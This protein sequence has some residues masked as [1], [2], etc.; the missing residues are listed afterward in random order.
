[1][2]LTDFL[3]RL[4]K[5]WAEDSNVKIDDGWGL[6]AAV[7]KEK[8][9]YTPE[10]N[11]SWIETLESWRFHR[12]CLWHEC[13]HLIYSHPSEQV[14]DDIEK[15]FTVKELSKLSATLIQLVYNIIEDYRIEK[16]GLLEYPGYYSEKRF[17]AQLLHENLIKSLE[18]SN[19]EVFRFLACFCLSL[20]DNISVSKHLNERDQKLLLELLNLCWDVESYHDGIKATQEVLRRLLKRFP[21]LRDK[22]AALTSKKLRILSRLS[23]NGRRYA[24]WE[25]LPE[26]SRR[27]S[28]VRAPQPIIREYESLIKA[29][30]KASFEESQAESSEDLMAALRGGAGRLTP[31]RPSDSTQPFDVPSFMVNRLIALLRQWRGGW[32]EVLSEVG[33]DVEV[34]LY[35]LDRLR[36]N[37]ERRFWLDEEKLLPGGP[38]ALLLDLSGSIASAGLVEDYLRSAILIGKALS[39]LNVPFSI[40]AF[41]DPDFLVVKQVREPWSRAVEAR[42]SALREGAG[43]PLCDALKL[44]LKMQPI[45]G[46]RYL[47]VLTDGLPNDERASM[48]MIREFEARGIKVLI[49][50]FPPERDVEVH[51]AFFRLVNRKPS[52]L[53]IIYKISELP[54]AFFELLK[55]N[56]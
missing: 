5:L 45:E 9:I 3:L 28:E 52:K 43:T 46:F 56:S 37:D 21:D 34:E 32:R 6:F 38:I 17:T 13:M 27:L 8:L 20:V 15:N 36:R 51:S 4:V 10:I 1:M 33:D 54:L 49:L 35:I 50:G 42:L 23:D 11:E 22:F 30:E 25:E 48:E 24:L 2:Q 7:I 47:V 31:R 16:L 39:F 29:G 18:E 53:K 26:E 44:C 40:Y 12:F 41:A 19:N 55:L 14:F